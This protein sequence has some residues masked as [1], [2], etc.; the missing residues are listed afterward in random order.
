M[1]SID[2]LLNHVR[3]VILK[4]M[5]RVL[6]VLVIVLLSVLVAFFLSSNREENI[7]SEPVNRQYDVFVKDV[8]FTETVKGG[9]NWEVKAAVAKFLQKEDVVNLEKVSAKLLMPDGRLYTLSGDEGKLF[10][11]TRDIFLK[12]NVILTPDRGERIITDNVWYREAEKKILTDSPVAV[13]GKKVKITGS[14]LVVDLSK[15]SIV[16][17][18]SVKAMVKGQ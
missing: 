17:K 7:L 14:G 3:G 12:G 5:I 10:R 16:V 9:S 11:G 6:P 13:E 8:V 4:K 1:I 2:S 18:N 15:R